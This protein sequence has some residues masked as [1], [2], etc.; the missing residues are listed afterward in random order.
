MVPFTPRWERGNTAA[1][2]RWLQRVTGHRGREPA[3]TKGDPEALG[4]SAGSKIKPRGA[5]EQC[6]T[7]TGLL[8]AASLCF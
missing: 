3:P 6:G 5:N 2:Q 7:T 8:R 1:S 4:D